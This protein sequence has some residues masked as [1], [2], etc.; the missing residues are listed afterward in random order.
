MS[1]PHAQGFEL[2]MFD[3][4]GTLVE[5]AP[6]IQD[7][8]NDTLER[9]GLEPVAL[10]DVERWIG[11]GT[12]E[13]LV[14]ALS[15][16]CGAQPEAVHRSELLD[17][18]FRAFKGDYERRCGSRSRLYPQV[19]DALV[20]LGERGVRRVLVTNKER[21][22]ADA[23]LHRHGLHAMLDGIVC[24]DTLPTR[25]P[26]PAGV[27][28]CMQEHATPARRALFVGD[29]SIDIETARNAGIAVWAVTYGYNMGSPIAQWRPDRLIDDFNC[30]LETSAS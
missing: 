18:A 17:V 8:V 22:F 6:E 27:L 24:G 26:D 21:R 2:V 4:D 15:Q 16:R 28:Q 3:L 14:Q 7:A 10:A 25:K 13:L 29:S 20:A 5:T 12:K 11:H 23:V 30:F 1:A 9:L 19:S